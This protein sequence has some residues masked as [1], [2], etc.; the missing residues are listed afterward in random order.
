MVYEATRTFATER[1][2]VQT[3]L[4]KTRG[5]KLRR[6]VLLVPVLRAGLGMLDPIPGAKSA[7]FWFDEFWVKVGSSST[8]IT[9]TP[10]EF[11]VAAIAVMPPRVVVSKVT[12]V[13]VPLLLDAKPA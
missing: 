13:S 11:V 5:V 2:T 6:E 8:E 10:K 1:V 3:P 4:E 9:V 7:R 12:R